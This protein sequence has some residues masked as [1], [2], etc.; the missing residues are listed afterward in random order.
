[1]AA[2][3]LAESFAERDNEKQLSLPAPPVRCLWCF[4][5]YL[6]E[7]PKYK[8][9]SLIQNPL[10]DSPYDVRLTTND[11]RDFSNW[12][13]SRRKS[14]K[15]MPKSATGEH[16]QVVSE[17]ALLGS[18]PKPQYCNHRSCAKPKLDGDTSSQLRHLHGFRWHSKY[19]ARS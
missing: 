4:L 1:M 5:G 2:S 13:V 19:I 15:A 8:T 17:I 9:I 11:W 12:P 10:H 7:L 6:V 16:M 14:Q 18:V 3:R